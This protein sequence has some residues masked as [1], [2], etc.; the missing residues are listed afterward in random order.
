MASLNHQITSLMA[1]H[2]FR[3][4]RQTKHKIFRHA[5]GAQVAV[6]CT[7]SDYRVLGNIEKHIRKALREAADRQQ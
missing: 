2:G 7:H 3:L 5:S 1:T 6:G 4:V